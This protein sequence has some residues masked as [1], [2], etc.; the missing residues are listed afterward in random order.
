MAGVYNGDY[1]GM[2]DRNYLGPPAQAAGRGQAAIDLHAHTS[3]SANAR[4][5]TTFSVL[6][7]VPVTKFTL[8][9]KGG[10]RG[11]LVVTGNRSLC[12]ASKRAAI[13][14]AGQNSRRERRSITIVTPCRPR[15][16]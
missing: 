13:L 10:N 14:L 15:S 4:L 11:I 3:V 12:K 9:I 2:N 8:T 6:P 16:G 1:T 5:V 7:D